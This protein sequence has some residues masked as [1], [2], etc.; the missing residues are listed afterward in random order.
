MA[1]YLGRKE[2]DLDPVTQACPLTTH[3]PPAQK[4]A[5]PLTLSHNVML[6]LA[7]T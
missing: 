1:L 5:F 3:P 4:Y 6:V 7:Q 2:R